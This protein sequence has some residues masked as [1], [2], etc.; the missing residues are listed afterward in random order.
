V[1]LALMAGISA[2][3]ERDAR[4]CELCNDR[5]AGAISFTC[6]RC[7]L[8]VCE[9]R[10]WDFERVRCRL[11]VQNRVPALPI[12]AEWWERNIGPQARRGRCQLCQSSA[13]EADLRSC[14]KCGRPQCRE[15]WDDA[16]GSCSRCGWSCPALPDGLK[17]FV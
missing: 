2:W 10:C 13:E 7:G 11:C 1:A 4:R 14:P 6:P 16:N 3:R 15:C 9:A 17:Q 8:P 12:E 5:L